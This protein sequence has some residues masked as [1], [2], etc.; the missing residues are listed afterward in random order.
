[1]QNYQRALETK[2]LMTKAVTAA[3]F[4]GLQEI[5]S[6]VL[7]GKSMNLQRIS[8]FSLYGKGLV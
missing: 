2:P 7:A 8:K 5:V 6:D 3:L 4:C 1:M